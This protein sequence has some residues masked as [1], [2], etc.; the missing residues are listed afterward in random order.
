MKA[1]FVFETAKFKINIELPLLLRG[2]F[3]GGPGGPWI[4][5]SGIRI[6]QWIKVRNRLFFTCSVA[7]LRNDEEAI[8]SKLAAGKGN[9]VEPVSAVTWIRRSPELGGHLAWDGQ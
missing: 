5:S 7:W 2:G 4:P 9:T 3:R 1:S 6:Q 8:P